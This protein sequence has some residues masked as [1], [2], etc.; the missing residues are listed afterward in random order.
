MVPGLRI[1]ATPTLYHAR[2]ASDAACAAA[3]SA[4]G[5]AV[6]LL[7]DARQA[8]L[9]QQR[10]A[11][12]GARFLGI[13]VTTPQRWIADRW[14]LFGDGR[15]PVDPATRRVLVLQALR[16]TDAKTIDVDAPGMVGCVEKV[17]RLGAGSPAFE[18]PGSRAKAGLNEA[19]LE[20]LAV[21]DRYRELLDARGLVET[22]SAATLLARHM[23]G[24]A[25]PHLVLDGL[26]QLEPSFVGLIAA[27]AANGGVTC[28]ARTN[29]GARGDAAHPAF[30][31]A[32]AFVRQ[33]ADACR[34]GGTPVETAAY[35]V[36]ES[37]GDAVAPEN[38]AVAPQ[39]PAPD[40]A[41]P[42]SVGSGCGPWVSRELAELFGRLFHPGDGT[43][44]EP[45]GDVAFLMPSGR[46]AEGRALADAIADIVDKGTA[47]RDILVACKDPLLTMGMVEAR[48]SQHGI[49]CRASGAVPVAR[50]DAGTAFLNLLRLIR[51]ERAATAPDER[52]RPDL[53]HVATDLA[54]NP[55]LGIATKDALELDASWRSMRLTGAEDL[56]DD[57]AAAIPD[58]P[59]LSD[60]IRARDLGATVRGLAKA[61]DRLGWDARSMTQRGAAATLARVVEAAEK[62]GIDVTDRGERLVETLGAAHSPLSI[63]TGSLA[64]QRNAA[65]LKGNPNAVRFCR[66]DSV[67]GERARTM[68]VCDLTAA[69]YP[70]ADRPDAATE[71]LCALGISAKTS[72]ID[73]LRWQFADAVEA[74][75]E[76]LVLE[77]ALNDE[78][79]Q[80][81]RPAALLE[82]VVDCYRT[83]VTDADGLDKVYGLPK[84]GELPRIECVGEERFSDGAN[85]IGGGFAPAIID[86]PAP[87]RELASPDSAQLLADPSRPLSPS[88]IESYISCPARWFFERRVSSDSLD[89]QFGP[90]EIGS[91]T[92]A[93]LHDVH[94]ELARRG[95]ARITREFLADNTNALAL[96]LIVEECFD[97]QRGRHLDDLEE[98]DG[99]LVPVGEL[100]QRRL[101]RLR[102]NILAHISNDAELPAGFEPSLH[103]WSFGMHGD[104]VGPIPYAGVKLR[105]RI[106]RVDVDA[107]GRAL[108]VDYK[109]GVGTG[110]GLPRPKRG[111]EDELPDPLVLHS[112][113]LMY[114]TALGRAG[115]GLEPV[116]ALY[117]SYSSAD[118]K[119]FLSTDGMRLPPD[120]AIAPETFVRMLA[121]G[122]EGFSDLLEYTEEVAREALQG[123]FGG[124][125][126]ARPRFGAD[127]CR[128]C[129][130]PDCPK[131]VG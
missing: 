72:S 15:Q 94:V 115:M 16:S 2:L 109:G 55:L 5:R 103:E 108:I 57:L 121:G 20:V 120:P 82:E 65:V 9:V 35:P 102:D 123:M 39:G 124:D 107:G 34:T 6:R 28:V 36:A 30:A 59:G 18:E 128:Y 116:G 27:A 100:E 53:V 62:A 4:C 80:A 51:A 127:S 49:A 122:L 44:V 96:R 47:P 86:V 95:C 3:V 17:V 22:G 112:Q 24:A 67:E 90:L 69:A 92:H 99:R 70:L 46:Y 88:A 110:Y 14:A 93:V 33:L 101:L 21:C 60:A 71:L 84:S 78:D 29:V 83:D 119:G 61:C 68:V 125:V 66:L 26:W 85:P 13:D 113:A 81:L 1:V 89:A 58:D 126:A 45:C 130:V 73:R 38:P 131:R 32:D 64:A 43:V 25:W 23:A 37:G 40:P 111:H 117:V 63:P 41:Y 50:S 91:F 104:D 75:C 79:A 105:G 98:V 7:P 8:T 106:D 54:R 42:A 48:L 10:L 129:T 12:D 74:A 76:S 97:L 56:L 11:D 19:Q 114:A 77:R 87:L 31:M 118:V 52:P